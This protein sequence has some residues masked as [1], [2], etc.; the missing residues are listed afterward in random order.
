MSARQSSNPRSKFRSESRSTGRLKF[1]AILVLLGFIAALV[2]YVIWLS[3]LFTIQSIEVQGASLKEEELL[4]KSGSG[5]MLFW[6]PPI[7]ESE[8]PQVAQLE[9]HKNFLKRKITVDFKKREKVLMWCLMEKQECFWVDETGFIFNE[10]PVPTGALLIKVVSDYTPRELKIGERALPEEYFR[11]LKV[12]FE[13]VDKLNLPVE[14]V[15]IE[16]LEFKEANAKVTNG[17]E[18]YFSFLVDPRFAKSVIEKLQSTGE[19]NQIRYLDLRVEN[20]AYYSQ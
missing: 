18:I 12:A 8:T 20:R 17:P 10:A 9:V 15:K 14:Q 16:N 11:N 1:F 13:L 19:W 6:K 4:K 3:P 2:I 5:N 7:K